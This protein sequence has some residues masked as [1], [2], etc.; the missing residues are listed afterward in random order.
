MQQGFFTAMETRIAAIDRP[1][2]PSEKQLYLKSNYHRVRT[3]TGSEGLSG[4]GGHGRRRGG[5]R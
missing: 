1:V 5:E 4:A 3:G 2:F